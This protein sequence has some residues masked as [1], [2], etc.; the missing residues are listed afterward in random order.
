LQQQLKDEAGNQLNQIAKFNDDY[1]KAWNKGMDGIDK[2][3]HT[4]LQLLPGLKNLFDTIVDRNAALEMGH[5]IDEKIHQA[6][7]A[8]MAVQGAAGLARGVAKWVM[9]DAALEAG[10]AAAGLATKEA[11]GGLAAKEGVAG[12]EGEAGVVS[13]GAQK[14]VLEGAEGA[15][16][17]AG[18]EEVASAAGKGSPIEGEPGFP[19]RDDAWGRRMTTS[20]P[21]LDSETKWAINGYTGSDYRGI[22][23]ALRAGNPGKWGNTVAKI[24]GAMA[25]LSE[26]VTVYRSAPLRSLGE[27]NADPTSLVGKVISD[28][29][30]MSTT[31]QNQASVASGAVKYEIECPAGTMGRYIAPISNVPAEEEVLLARNLQL[32]VQSVTESPHVPGVWVVKARV[33]IP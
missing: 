16:E 26:P 28:K 20:Q 15:G 19:A 25:P 21:P 6:I 9:E 5:A 2:Y 14:G 12:L 30:F 3:L 22:N 29:G 1:N 7:G 31:L 8:V 13:K 4:Y 32:V 33:V 10:E 17:A 18:K 23:D 11:A 27:A 24:D